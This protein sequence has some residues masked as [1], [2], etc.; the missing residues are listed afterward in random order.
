MM[1]LHPDAADALR[2]ILALARAQAAAAR[3]DRL[4]GTRV[5]HVFTRRGKLL[6]ATFLFDMALRLRQVGRGAA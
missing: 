6:S 5:R 3:H 2:R 1:P 4:A